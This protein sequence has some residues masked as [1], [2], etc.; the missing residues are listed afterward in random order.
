AR[1]ESGSGLSVD[2]A[3]LAPGPHRPIGGV[4]ADDAGAQHDQIEIGIGRGDELGE[5]SVEHGFAARLREASH[6]PSV[7]SLRVSPPCGG[8]LLRRTA[9]RSLSGSLSRSPVL[10]PESFRGGC[11]FGAG[12]RDPALPTACTVS[13]I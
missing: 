13:V 5:R 8:L 7:M 12:P 4:D 9:L 10:E 3:N 6:A 11:S 2:D 1:L